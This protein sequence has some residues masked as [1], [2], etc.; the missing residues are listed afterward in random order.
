MRKLFWLLPGLILAFVVF[1]PLSW[2]GP[3]VVPSQLTKADTRYQGTVW[4]GQINDLQDVETVTF[5]LNPFKFLG[6]DLPVDARLS[7]N[8]LQANG[9]LAQSQAEDV[10][11]R[12]NVASLPLPDPRLR[13]LAGQ[14][15][16]QLDTVEW[17][18]DGQCQTV[19]GTVQ[20]DIL[21][22]NRSLF[23]WTGPNL[24]GPISC[25]GNGGYLFAMSGKDDVQIIEANVSISALGTYKSDI[26][27]VTR[28]QEATLVLPLFGFEERGQNAEGIEFRLI[29]QGS[30][31]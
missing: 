30:W 23:S 29:E 5:T 25:D 16:A 12:I 21:M 3:R 17:S 4:N 10:S 9:K 1:L 13:G 28:D 24:S 27:V 15:T 19:S 14:M 26:Q 6:S 20:S 22:R 18:K 11:L 8:G 7:A 31:R 2:V